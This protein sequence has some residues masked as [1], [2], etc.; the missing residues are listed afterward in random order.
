[1]PYLTALCDGEIAELNHV[2]NF[3]NIYTGTLGGGFRD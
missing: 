2:E 1:M 3:L